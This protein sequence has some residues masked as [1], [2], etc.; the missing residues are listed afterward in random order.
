LS[1]GSKTCNIFFTRTEAVNR[2]S[3]MSMATALELSRPIYEI[4]GHGEQVWTIGP[5]DHPRHCLETLVILPGR[6]TKYCDKYVCLSAGI[7]RK[8]HGRTSPNFFM[9][10]ARSFSGGVAI[11]YVLP[12]LWMT[13]YFHVIALWRITCIPERRQNATSIKVEIPTEICSATNT[14]KYSS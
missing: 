13:S 3:R 8:P 14:S 7:S 1:K 11:R 9:P 6:S 12:V 4:S 2:S 10:V 5:F